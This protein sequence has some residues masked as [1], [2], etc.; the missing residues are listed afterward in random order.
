MKLLLKFLKDLYLVAFEL[1]HFE[2]LAIFYLFE[3]DPDADELELEKTKVKEESRKAQIE[4]AK[5]MEENEQKLRAN[6][7]A[8]SSDSD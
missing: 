6:E 5:R 1:S 3:V 4:N 2:Q 7:Q 8:V